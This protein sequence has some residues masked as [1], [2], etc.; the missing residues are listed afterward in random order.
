MK[1]FQAELKQTLP[2]LWRYAFSLSGSR[3]NA[4][5]IVQDCAEKAIRKHHQWNKDQPIKPWLMT[6]VLNIYRNQYR[7]DTFLRL[8]PIQDND[9]G[10][11]YTPDMENRQE[12]IATMHGINQLPPEQR[13]ALLSVVI[14]GLDYT[15][16]AA[17]LNIA[18]GTLMSRIFRARQK[19]KQLRQRETETIRSIK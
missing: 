5:D 9:T 1:K 13:E 8:V 15:Q 7:R 19:L 6:I 2:D 3:E 4:D 14:G 10:Q 18:R 11:K 17:T 16:A 12:L